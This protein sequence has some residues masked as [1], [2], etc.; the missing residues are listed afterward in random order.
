MGRS[1]AGKSTLLNC[2]ANQR[3]LA[4]TS[5]TAGRTQLIHVFK[6]D[7]QRRLIDLPG[8][9]YAKASHKQVLAWQNLMRQYLTHR[10]CLRG[11][12]VLMDCRYPLQALDQQLVQW[13]LMHQLALQIVLTKVDKL[14]QK[15]LS[16]IQSG[17][18]K[19]LKSMSYGKNV[20]SFSSKTRS[21]LDALYR[22]LDHWF[23]S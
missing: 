20:L 4:R 11:L 23:T 12:V 10:R 22:L 13:A 8:Y 2:I 9:G 5:K 7:Q 17:L 14:T 19:D 3:K 18:E 21:H 16:Q 15:G 1:N 6:L